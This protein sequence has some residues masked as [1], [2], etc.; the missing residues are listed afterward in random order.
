VPSLILSELLLPSAEKDARLAVQTAKA[1]ETLGGQDNHFEVYLSLRLDHESN[2]AAKLLFACDFVERFRRGDFLCFDLPARADDIGE[3]C[4]LYG[5]YLKNQ[6][7]WI[8]RNQ[9]ATNL[10]I[11]QRRRL[12]DKRYHRIIYVSILCFLL[13]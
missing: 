7:Q 2:K 11:P 13:D 1:I 12:R 10:D 5:Q 3:I 8:K 6:K 9:E 4:R